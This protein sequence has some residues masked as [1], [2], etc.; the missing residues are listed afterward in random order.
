MKAVI[1]AAGMGKRLK[2]I[3]LNI[4]KPLLKIANTTIIEYLIS[5]LKEIGV[6]D[7]FV[8]TGYKSKLI[9]KKIGSQVTYLHNKKYKTTNSIYSLY[10]AK[11]YLQ[12]S[13]FILANGDIL[14]SQKCLSKVNSFKSSTSFGIKRNIYSDGEM[15]IISKNRIIKQIS[16]DIDKAKSN[17]ESAQ[18]SYFKKKDSIILFNRVNQ[19][20]RKKM[21]NLFPAYAYDVVIKKSKLKISFINKKCWYEIDTRSDLVKLRKKIK[22]IKQLE[23]F[24]NSK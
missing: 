24:K 1:L 18:I 21:F 15:N 9:K 3:T 10:L 22:T 20:I 17:A 2:D 7:I 12:N 6:K 23:F 14:L 4:P 13:D 11:K 5:S 16:K 8:V 19:L